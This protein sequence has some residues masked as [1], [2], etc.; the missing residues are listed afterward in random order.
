MRNVSIT[1]CRPCGYE[2]RAKEAAAL[3]RE[4]LGVDATLIPGKGGIFEVKLGDEVVA[5]R[6]KGHFPDAAEIVAA[7]T[8]ARDC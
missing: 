6:A 1:Y 4:R 2:K 3:L 7:V 5:R 8:A